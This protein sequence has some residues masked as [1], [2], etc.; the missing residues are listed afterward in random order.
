M[1]NSSI[2]NLMQGNE[3][4]KKILNLIAGLYAFGILSTQAATTYVGN[5]STAWGGG[6]GN[7][8]IVVNDTVSGTLTFQINATTPGNA[9]V[10]YIDSVSGGFSDNS[11][12]SDAGDGLRQAISGWNGSARS[13]L[14]LPFAADFAI[15]ADT[16][17]AGLWQLASGG[18]N[19]LV[20][21]AGV[22]SFAGSG[23]V[24]SLN[25]SDLGLTANS[26]QS[27]NFAAMMVST[28]GYSS[29]EAIGATITGTYG[30]GGT[31]TIT[32]GSTY[33]TIPEPSSSLLMGLGLAGLAALRCTRKNA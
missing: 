20:W 18:N 30:H 12:L 19:S 10:I 13:G 1:L 5:G 23:S 22:G 21:K 14:N 2:S 29:P 9:M 8:N 31:Q 32:S 3:S 28:T 27:F 33:T 15:A 7:G 4:M 17:Y 26:S 11:P 24:L 25:V 16:N 6:F